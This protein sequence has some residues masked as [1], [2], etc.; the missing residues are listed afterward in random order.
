M[1]AKLDRMRRD[2]KI[3]PAVVW[4]VDFNCG[5]PDGILFLTIFY[6]VNGQVKQNKPAV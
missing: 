4:F 1:D 6:I 2:L 3:N 5:F